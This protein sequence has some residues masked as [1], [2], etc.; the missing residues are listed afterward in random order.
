MPAYT[1]RPLS[2]PTIIRI[3]QVL[4]Q[5]KET[6][7]VECCLAEYS[8]ADTGKAHH[9][10][11]LSYVWG[12]QDDPESILVDGDDF[13]VGRNLHTALLHIR[14]DQIVRHLWVDAI[15]INQNNEDE[16]A[17]Q[18][19]LMRD[20]Y[21]HA[22]R[23]IVWL[24]NVAD[25]SD[26]VFETIRLAGERALAGNTCPQEVTPESEF[27]QAACLELLNRDWFR[28]IWVLQEVGVARDISIMC[29]AAEIHGYIFCLG[30]RRLKLDLDGQ[31]YSALSLMSGAIA[32]P[33]YTPSTRGELSMAEL[34]DMYHTRAAT[35]L[36]DKIYAL[37]GL[38]CD[39]R[40]AAALIPDYTAPWD[41]VLQRFVTYVLPS[42][43]RVQTLPD[44]ESVFLTG[45]GYTIGQ[46]SS[47]EGYTSSVRQSFTITFVY[48]SCAAHFKEKWGSR[49]VIGPSAKPVRQ[50]DVLIL[51][52]GAS[53]P[54]V[55][56]LYEGYP[57]IIV[58]AVTSQQTEDTHQHI[59]DDG[60]RLQPTRARH[61]I[62]RWRGES[63]QTEI[64]MSLETG[65][66]DIS[67]IWS[68]KSC[69]SI[70]GKGGEY[71]CPL[72][73]ILFQAPVE[74]KDDIRSIVEDLVVE[75]IA[76]TDWEAV[77]LILDQV[78]I[79]LPV[80]AKVLC[81]AATSTE[82][83]HFTYMIK[84]WGENGLP[85]SSQVLEA[86]ARNFYLTG[87]Q[88]MQHHRRDMTQYTT[89]RVLQAALTNPSDFAYYMVRILC[90]ESGENVPITE[91]VLKAAA[92]RSRGPAR[93]IMLFLCK[94]GGENLPITED[95][96]KVAVSHAS[97]ANLAMVIILCEYAG[98]NPP[99]TEDVLKV[100]SGLDFFGGA[101][102]L[103]A[104]CELAG[105]DP[106]I[107]EDVLK[108]VAER[109]ERN[110]DIFMKILFHYGNENLRITEAV[111]CEVVGNASPSA[112]RLMQ[113]LCQSSGK[114]LP[115]TEAVVWRA[116]TNKGGGRRSRRST[117]FDRKVF[118][119]YYGKRTMI[120]FLCHYGRADVPITDEM[121]AYEIDDDPL[122]SHILRDHARKIRSGS[123]G[124]REAVRKFR[125]PGKVFCQMVR[126]A[127]E[128]LGVNKDKRIY[129]K[130]IV[131]IQESLRDVGAE[132]KF[133][134]RRWLELK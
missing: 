130:N 7:R 127:K 17:R 68:W 86:A 94:H 9:Y 4:P 132:T 41:K 11:A 58:L 120:E 26:L 83:S 107:T 42:S 116:L 23:V 29:G 28:R 69:I 36:H 74:R 27:H 25:N 40:K 79:T 123:W 98:G 13:Q 20:I 67:L 118:D 57:V 106:P 113:W 133:K 45:K 37:L 60:T 44:P 5:S 24:G 90:G 129:E 99:I 110:G 104:L 114:H 63:P 105:G 31:V 122:T 72:Q 21:G 22:H 134:S 124:V 77:N 96:L 51:L 121:I 125:D 111:L 92:A 49:W 101:A 54:S 52:E 97:P 48:T 119:P 100:A 56:R 88:L 76:K 14:D 61:I 62:P 93:D 102:I 71:E 81:A 55:I 1:Y 19:P 59:S 53:K 115:I 33:R 65:S 85:I 32:R 109:T 82:E 89:D 50:G 47:I 73:S 12:N 126:S 35:Q 3:L 30:L 103:I 87:L 8:L 84:A 75:R 112:P 131:W 39:D 70:V 38:T 95:V 91:D 117:L 66:R 43:F 15:C 6:D 10:E 128:S 2:E 108:A 80:T 34:V 78:G 16:K 18:I 46:I 64:T